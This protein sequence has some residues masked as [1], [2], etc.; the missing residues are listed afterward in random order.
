MGIREDIELKGIHVISLIAG[1]ICDGCCAWREYVHVMGEV[2]IAEAQ[3]GGFE[4]CESVVF[5][6]EKKEVLVPVQIIL[7]M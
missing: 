3:G 6:A 4:I 5:G 7:D 2:K 1:S